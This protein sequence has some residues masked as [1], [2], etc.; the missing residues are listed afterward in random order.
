MTLHIHFNWHFYFCLLAFVT[1]WDCGFFAITRKGKIGYFFNAWFLR[2]RP[3]VQ[4]FEHEANLR[5]D[6]EIV[7]LLAATPVYGGHS[8]FQLRAII[9]DYM[10]KNNIFSSEDTTAEIL[11]NL[12]GS[13]TNK[14][15]YI[16]DVKILP[17]H[18]TDPIVT[19]ITC[20]ASVHSLIIYSTVCVIL[21][22]GW[23][24]LEWAALAIPAAFTGEILWKLK[25]KLEK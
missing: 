24:P 11:A 13:K 16:K 7:A 23:N 21:G 22:I 2:T 20:M 18:L 5:I 6:S 10:N 4:N 12:Q 17:D 15:C 1:V 3:Q 14:Y 9:L 19:C 25:A 8:D